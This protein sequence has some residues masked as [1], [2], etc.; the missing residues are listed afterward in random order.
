MALRISVFVDEPTRRARWYASCWLQSVVDDA[1]AVLVGTVAGFGLRG[2]ATG[3][4]IY[5]D[6]CAREGYCLS[7]ADLLPGAISWRGQAARNTQ[8]NAIVSDSVAVVVT[9]VTD[10]AA[11][12]ATRT[13]AVVD[14][15]IA[16]IVLAVARFGDWAMGWASASSLVF[17]DGRVAVVVRVVADFTRVIAKPR[18]GGLRLDDCRAGQQRGIATRICG[19]NRGPVSR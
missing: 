4:I 18:G 11:W 10:L 16:I 7:V 19:R 5:R 13:H 17:V 9:T 6:T 12:Y 2:I 15:A 3:S 14:D 8:P 1:V